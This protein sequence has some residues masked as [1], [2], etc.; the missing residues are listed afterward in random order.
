[1]IATLADMVRRNTA[2]NQI[3]VDFENGRGDVTTLNDLMDLIG[4]DAHL[5]QVEISRLSDDGYRM[6][7]VWFSGDVELDT[8]VSGNPDDGWGYADVWN[9]TLAHLAV[10][11]AE[12][13]DVIAVDDTSPW[14]VRVWDLGHGQA[15][16]WGLT[17]VQAQDMRDARALLDTETAG[18][19]SPSEMVAA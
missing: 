11:V 17:P 4:R 7:T 19:L 18:H 16:Y 2:L 9:G 8:I 5:Y 10:L 3:C 15:E 13:Q 6:D 12:N 1:M 14:R